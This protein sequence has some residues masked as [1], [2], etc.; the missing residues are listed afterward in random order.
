MGDYTGIERRYRD[1]TGA[2]RVLRFVR[3]GPY[4]HNYVL[5]V[6]CYHSYWVD[7]ETGEHIQIPDLAWVVLKMKFEDSRYEGSKEG[8]G[9]GGGA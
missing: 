1:L 5:G 3:G 6:G 8:T 4:M 2:L 7:L 9:P